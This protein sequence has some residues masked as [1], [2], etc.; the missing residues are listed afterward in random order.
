MKKILL[1]TIAAATVLFAQNQTYEISVTTGKTFP[2]ADLSHDEHHNF[3]V[4]LGF[5]NKL[6]LPHIFDTMELIYERSNVVDYKN[7]TLKTD[8]DRYSANL[9]H[10]FDPINKIS[11]YIITGLGYEDFDPTYV[12]FATNDS[13]IANLGAGLKYTIDHEWNI[14]AELRDQIN[15]ESETEHEFIYTIGLG[16]TFEVKTEPKIKEEKIAPSFKQEQSPKKQPKDSDGDGVIDTKDNCPTTPKG[17]KVD[18]NGCALDSDGDG[19]ID[20]YDKCPNTIKGFKVD[21]DGC[22]LNY[23]FKVQFDSDK[24]D[25]KDEYLATLKKFVDFMNMMSKYKADIQGHTDSTASSSYNMELSTK[26]A[27]AVM[28]KLI[29]LGIKADRLTYKGFGENKPI[30]TNKTENGKAINRRV[31]A[32][33]EK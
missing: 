31:E 17:A 15:F 30:A 19:V 9:L 22:P 13:L 32:M 28:D 7:T 18:I 16:Y 2:E 5:E 29:E 8:I 11:P 10:T 26:R 1:S 24:Y 14:R 21:K 3:G 27:K 4:R 6:I 12:G 23:N 33:I 20:L 25:V